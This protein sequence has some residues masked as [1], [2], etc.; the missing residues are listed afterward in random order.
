[1][2]TPKFHKFPAPFKRLPEPLSSFHFVFDGVGKC[3]FYGL[4][5][6]LVTFF[7]SLISESTAEAMWRDI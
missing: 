2:T 7:S 4:V 3:K 1:M 6:K 5:W